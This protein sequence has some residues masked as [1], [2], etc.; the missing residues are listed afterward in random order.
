MVENTETIYIYSPTYG[1]GDM[2]I[3]PQEAEIADINWKKVNNLKAETLK[4]PRQL[5]VWFD[6]KQGISPTTSV[7]P[8]SS[9]HA[10]KI[11]SLRPPPRPRVPTSTP[12][13]KALL[14]IPENVMPRRL[15]SPALQPPLKKSRT[16]V[17]SPL[18]PS[19]PIL[20]PS[21]PIQISTAPT[22]DEREGD[23]VFVAEVEPPPPTKRKRF[24][25]MP[26][27]TNTLTPMWNRSSNLRK[28]AIAISPPHRHRIEKFR[29]A[30][31]V[32]QPPLQISTAPTT[33]ESAELTRGRCRHRRR[34]RATTS[35]QE[36]A[37]PEAALPD[38]YTYSYVE[39]IQ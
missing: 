33:D 23:A 5:R 8:S 36:E 28:V 22:T 15:S 7:D 3:V 18:Q 19:L 2:V 34:G 14:P 32:R 29:Q 26:A 39:Q 9:S 30:F 17:H 31:D 10:I 6:C 4:L 25:K 24:P 21:L 11:Y 38:E 13:A 12:P 1:G 35:N 20:Q 16:K 37:I 27:P